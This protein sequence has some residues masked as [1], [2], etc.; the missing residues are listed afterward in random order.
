MARANVRSREIA[1][2]AAL[3]ASRY[4]IVR[5]LLTES[6][7]LS[8]IG[9]TVGFAIGTLGM[10]AL[11]SLNSGNIP[12]VGE[13]GTAVSMDWTVLA[14]TLMLTLIT[15][16]FFGLAPALHASRADIHAM[17]K[18]GA[19]RFSS[20][21]RQ[22]RMRNTLVVGEIAIAIVLLTGAGLLVRTFAALHNVVPGFDPHHVL[23]META[24][25]GTAYDRTDAITKMSRHAIERIEAIPGVEAAAASSY[26]PLDSSYGLGFNIEGK[27][28]TD[29]S[30]QGF[31]AWSY[32]TSNFFRVLK[33]P[34]VRGRAFTERDDAASPPVV[35]INEA[36][37]KQYW[38]DEEPLGQRIMIGSAMGPGFTQRGREIVGVVANTRE[39]ALNIDPQPAMFVPLSQVPDSYMKLNNRFMPLR[40]LVRS[41]LEPPHSLSPAINR[42]FAEVADLPAGHVRTM[43]RIVTS[44]TAR[45]EF[46]TL[47]LSIFAFIAIL[48]ATIGLYAVVAFS[49]EQRTHELGIRLALG[50]SFPQVRNMIV[51][52]AMRLA[53]IGIAIGLVAARG[54]TRLL[55]SMLFQVKD[56]DPLVFLLV[57]LLLGAVAFF[58]S[59]LPARRAL[60]LDPIVALRYQ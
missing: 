3:G 60:R 31:A 11:I 29:A 54:F 49:V 10:R 23:T 30:E 37:A 48:L 41:H 36:L 9:G 6:L 45:H 7:L 43:D 21:L 18:E 46:N 40:W 22:N 5:Q 2:R 14:F 44:S 26:L 50:A 52:Q 20:G 12:R 56:N 39:A 17:L 32:V 27:A 57:A 28:L 4:R 53:I 1:V 13:N 34:V 25:T 16:L 47:M 59:Y 58:A 38:K 33:I 51:L 8:T 35:V 24:L 55:A 15:S 42:S 19:S